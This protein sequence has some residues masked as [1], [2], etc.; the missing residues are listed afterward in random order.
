M[1][2]LSRGHSLGVAEGALL[3]GPSLASQ[4]YVPAHVWSRVRA[5]AGLLAWHSAPG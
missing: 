3:A 4:M 1:G 5:V 2:C